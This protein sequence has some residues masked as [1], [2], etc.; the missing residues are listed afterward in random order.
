MTAPYA[1]RLAIVL[2]L[3][4]IV[5]STIHSA[6]NNQIRIPFG[7]ND[8]VQF[9]GTIEIGEDEVQEGNVIGFFSDMRIEGRVNGSVVALGGELDIGDDSS[10]VG[11]VVAVSTEELDVDE[12]N[13]HGDIV[14][15]NWNRVRVDAEG[16]KG[17]IV[18]G[19]DEIEGEILDED[20]VIAGK[21]EEMKG[22]L[23]ETGDEKGAKVPVEEKGRGPKTVKIM[24]DEIVKFWGDVKIKEDQI[25]D[26]EVVVMFGDLY[27][28]G[29]IRGEAVVVGGDMKFSETGLVEGEAVVV[30]GEFRSMSED[31]VRGEYVQVGWNGI[32]VREGN[33]EEVII[34]G[35]QE[36]EMEDAEDG[37]EAEDAA[38]EEEDDDEE[39]EK[40]YTLTIS[41]G[42]DPP[43]GF[44][45]VDGLYI[46]FRSS[47]GNEERLKARLKFGGSYAIKSDEWKYSIAVEKF[48]F[49]ENHLTFGFEIFAHSDWNY[50]D[51]KRIGT[52]ENSLAALLLKEDFRDYF[53]R[54]GI[55]GYVQQDLFAHHHLRFAYFRERYDSM[56]KNTDWAVFGKGKKFRPNFPVDEGEANRYVFL[57]TFDTTDGNGYAEN[58][59]NNVLMV[60]AMEPRSGELHDLEYSYRKIDAIVTRYTRIFPGNFF[61]CRLWMGYSE[62]PLPRQ[63]MYSLGGIGTLRGFRFKEFAGGDKMLMVNAEYRADLK[64]GGMQGAFFVDAGE[65]YGTDEKFNVKEFNT[66]VGLGIQDSDGDVRLDI[67]TPVSESDHSDIRITFR[68]NRTF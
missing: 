39:E 27:V 40:K 28:E 60:D 41:T 44:N 19:T 1:F 58:G 47:V 48:F 10:I 26:G 20:E 66:N 56:E 29:T 67:A 36:D 24:G 54:E 51:E 9:G 45:R 62:D 64:L 2:F 68:L 38:D 34:L 65:V 7:G 15:T 22:D 14:M 23:E 50:Q 42:I 43:I 63:A 37:D 4:A 30:G 61:D 53:W 6:Q 59:W 52:L 31:N 12:G 5:P 16:K 13:V 3:L 57:Y 8:L 46:G 49:E 25:V 21:T 18:I 55:Q 35:D 33:G 32:R 17:V 11:R